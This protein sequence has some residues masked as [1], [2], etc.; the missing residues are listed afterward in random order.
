MKKILFKEH[1][2]VPYDDG[3]YIGYSKGSIFELPDSEAERTVKEGYAVYPEVDRSILYDKQCN[4]EQ[5]I[6]LTETNN[7]K[8]S[9]QSK[10]SVII[11]ALIQYEKDNNIYLIKGN[12]DS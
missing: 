10:K 9:S 4:K 7:I 11:E 8:I 12:N 1:Y 6:G 5:L 2:F 3:R